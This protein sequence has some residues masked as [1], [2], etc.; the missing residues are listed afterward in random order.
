MLDVRVVAQPGRAIPT[1]PRAGVSC[2]TLPADLPVARSMVAIA[3][4]LGSG[5]ATVGA[6]ARERGR[7]SLL[8]PATWHN[9]SVSRCRLSC[10][11]LDL[12]PGYGVQVPFSGAVCSC[13]VAFYTTGLDQSVQFQRNATQYKDR[14]SLYSLY[15]GEHRLAGRAPGLK[16]FVVST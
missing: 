4:R 1:D 16:S 15:P 2:I 5:R 11:T 12:K 8:V 14:R 7:A 10:A 9:F 3:V 6:T 13:M